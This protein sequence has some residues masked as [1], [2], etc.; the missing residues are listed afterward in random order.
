MTGT[1]HSAQ[2][3]LVKMGPLEFFCLQWPCTAILPIS[4]S[5][6]AKISGVRH[7]NQ[8]LS[9]KLGYF[10]VLPTI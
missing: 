10:A 3:L 6:V 8:L 2:L 5:I 4:A 1:P 9:I 7:H